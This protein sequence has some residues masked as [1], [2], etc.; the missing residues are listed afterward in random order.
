VRILRHPRAVQPA[1]WLDDPGQRQPGEHLVPA[2]RLREPEVAEPV[3][4]LRGW[5]SS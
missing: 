4:D 2:R 5:L 3:G 1:H